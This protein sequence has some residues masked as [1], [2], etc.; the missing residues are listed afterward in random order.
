MKKIF[1]CFFFRCRAYKLKKD[2]DLCEHLLE[3]KNKYVRSSDETE[4]QE[5]RFD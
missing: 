2:I 5:M 4:K 1:W 3:N